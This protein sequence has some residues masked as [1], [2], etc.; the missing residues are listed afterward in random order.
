MESS[1]YEV[2]GGHLLAE[3]GFGRYSLAMPAVA[4]FFFLSG[5]GL[6]KKRM[7]GVVLKGG[8]SHAAIKLLPKFFIASGV[9]AIIMTA[10]GHEIHLGRNILAG[11]SSLPIP[12]TWYIPAIMLLY[13][14][15]YGADR[16]CRADKELIVCIALGVAVYW[17]MTALVFKWPFYWWKSVWGFVAGFVFAANE[18]KL[19]RAIARSPAAIY[20]SAVVLFAGIYGLDCIS[21]FPVRFFADHLFLAVLGPVVALVMY[22]VRIPGLFGAI[23]VISYEMYIVHGAFVGTFHQCI[24]NGLLYGC[25]VVLCSMAAAVVLK[26]SVRGLEFVV[27]RDK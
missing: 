8:F 17:L 3:L 20:F 18:E 27:R 26:W 16:F 11:S 15:F 1:F 2:V 10:C 4:V 13:G 21:Y 25:G 14:I 24:S 12:F 5:Y 23:G 22:R 9:Y 7:R 19:Q 6:M